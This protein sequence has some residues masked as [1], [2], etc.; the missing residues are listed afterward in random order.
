MLAFFLSIFIKIFKE[1]T[2]EFQN[3]KAITVV[4]IR[5]M[6]FRCG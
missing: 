6:L 2:H 4:F 1:K 3:S 5:F